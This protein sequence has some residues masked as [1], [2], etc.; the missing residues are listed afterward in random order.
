MSR[1][2]REAGADFGGPASTKRAELDRRL[3][4]VV[5][6]TATQS[7]Q[8]VARSIAERIAKLPQST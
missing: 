8:S 6:K 3:D 7:G 5:R 1:R 2:E 4:E